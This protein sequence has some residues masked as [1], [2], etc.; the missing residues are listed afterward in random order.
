MLK[1]NVREEV[2]TIVLC[3]SDF[4]PTDTIKFD[5]NIVPTF[6]YK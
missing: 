1:I 5:V 2:Y 4:S 3:I 6:R